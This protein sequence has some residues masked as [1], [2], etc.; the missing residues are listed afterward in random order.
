MDKHRQLVDQ[1][2]TR[3]K[4]GEVAWEGVDFSGQF[5]A[6]FP[7]FTLRLKQVEPATASANYL[8][9]IHDEEGEVLEEFSDTDLSD[10][11]DEQ[12]YYRQQLKET[13]E[14]ARRTA[15]GVEEA[16]DHILE[17]LEKSDEFTGE[18]DLPF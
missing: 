11:R 2:H 4:E 12:K 17:E 18:D 3:T 1:L 8:V 5:Q 13:F 10:D 15:M 14:I 6:V 9:T 7:R 16:L